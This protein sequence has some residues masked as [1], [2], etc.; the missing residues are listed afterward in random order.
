M[1]M[2][3]CTYYLSNEWRWMLGERILFSK[4]VRHLLSADLVFKV[5]FYL[6]CSC[7]FPS[8]DW[9]SCVISTNRP[10]TRWCG[11]G[12]TRVVSAASFTNPWWSLS[13]FLTPKMRNMLKRTFLIMIRRWVDRRKSLESRARK[14][15]THT[16]THA[17]THARVRAHTRTHNCMRLYSY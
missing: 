2:T 17:R 6:D 9:M 3:I 16:H 7:V 4:V 10:M 15:S 11:C 1:L 13:T 12:V 14:Q 8:S 5:S